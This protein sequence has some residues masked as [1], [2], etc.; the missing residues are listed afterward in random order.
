MPLTQQSID[1]L[2]GGFQKDL[3]R[4][5]TLYA[6]IALSGGTNNDN[7]YSPLLQPDRRDAAQFI[8]FEAAAKF[9]TFCNEA[10]R[11]EV[12]CEFRVLPKRANFIMGNIDRGLEGVMGWASPNSLQRRGQA[13]FGKRGFFARMEKRLGSQTYSRLAL[14]HK[15]RNRIAHARGKASRDFNAILGQLRVPA[16]SRKGLSVGR[17]LMDYPTTVQADDRW[18]YRFVESYRATA[19]DYHRYMRNRGQ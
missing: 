6:R 11:V 4:A 19:D 7:A 1:R 3:E 13:L 14:A 8:F 2:V 15:V 5:E 9:E 18:F 17:L 16:G 12:R 10:F